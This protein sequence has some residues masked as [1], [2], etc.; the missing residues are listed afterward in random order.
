MGFV[1]FKRAILNPCQVSLCRTP[2]WRTRH[3][4]GAQVKQ[5]AKLEPVGAVT[6]NPERDCIVKA[7]SDDN[8]IQPL[9][10]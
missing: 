8:L 2:S 3:Q 6:R 5:D 10:A 4:P 9:A 7:F 1:R